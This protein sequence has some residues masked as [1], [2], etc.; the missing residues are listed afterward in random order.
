MPAIVPFTI[1]QNSNATLDI[2]LGRVDP[3]LGF[4]ADDLTVI[5]GF[6]LL[7][8][9]YKAL[10]DTDLSVVTLSSAN[11]AQILVVSQQVHEVLLTVNITSTQVPNPGTLWWKLD[12]Y[13]GLAWRTVALG[14]VTVLDT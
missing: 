9:P 6:K 12:A 11:P 13:V 5:T 4:P 10:P 1:V 2:T 8:K 14:Q 3:D 7:L